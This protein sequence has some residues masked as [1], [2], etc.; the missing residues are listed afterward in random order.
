MPTEEQWQPARLIPVSALSGAEE[1]ER[2]GAS[3]LLAVIQVVRE[4]GRTITQ[5]CGAPAGAIEAF[6]EVPFELNGKKY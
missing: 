1:Q 2:R 4:F 5:K 3:V 6:I